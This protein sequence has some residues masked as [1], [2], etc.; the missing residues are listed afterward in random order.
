MVANVIAVEKGLSEAEQ[1]VLN[2]VRQRLTLMTRQKATGRLTF[3]I[4]IRDGGIVD[5]FATSRE[6]VGK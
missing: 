1:S 6:R 5:K 4:E 2:M 3:E